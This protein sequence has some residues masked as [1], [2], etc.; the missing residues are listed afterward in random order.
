MKILKNLTVVLVP[1]FIILLIC[2]VSLTSCVESKPSTDMG[3]NRQT[4]QLMR[5]AN[6]QLLGY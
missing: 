4:H 2:L 6:R 1:V 5:E 3:M